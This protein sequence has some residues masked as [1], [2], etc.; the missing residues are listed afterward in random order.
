MTN[1][2]KYWRLAG[3]FVIII[4]MMMVLGIFSFQKTLS[5]SNLTTRLHEHPFAVSNA[6]RDVNL[7]IISMHRYLKDVALS[8]NSDDLEAAIVKIR[9]EEIDVYED[10][11]FIISRF[12]GNKSRI[13]EARKAFSHWGNIRAEVISLA[14]AGKYDEAARITKGKGAKH[15]ILMMG[16]MD[17]LINFAN[18]KAAEFL[19]NSKDQ[20]AEFQQMIALLLIGAFVMSGLI[21]IFII[22]SVRNADAKRNWA[23][24][25]LQAEHDNLE[26]KVEHRTKELTL[27]NEQVV[28]QR[29]IL[30]DI[31]RLTKAGGWE[32]D[33]ATMQ[34][35]WSDET[36]RIH[37][38]S[39]DFVPDIKN[40]IEFY[41]PES[42]PIIKAAVQKGIE[43]GTPLDMELSL[44]TAQG[45]L[46]NVRVLGE[47]I[48]EDQNPKTL[49]GTFQDITPQKQTEKE[50]KQAR[51]E[52]EKANKAKSE[53]LASMSHDLRTPL[54][55][56]MGFSDMMRAEIFGPLGNPHYEEYCEDINNSGSLLIS[57]INDVLDLSKIE[58]GKYELAEDALDIST[59]VHTS[60]KQLEKMS[61]TANQTISINIPTDLPPLKGDERALIQ[62]FNNLLSNAIKFTPDGG[63]INISAGVDETQKM[64]VIHF[65]DSGI[66][67]SK[68]G[69]IKA[70][71]P[72]EQA[73][74]SH[75]R[76][77]KGTGLGLHLCV[78]FMKLFGGTLNIESDV[79][80]GTKVTLQFPPERTLPVSAQAQNL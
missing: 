14:R 40:A 52:A 54:N 44:I 45:N 10:L 33:I 16:Q 57:L 35:K 2:V 63:N 80:E 19:K 51:D 17:G 47:V 73:E 1:R 67:M 66:G 79:G 36:Y 20:N 28:R 76:R 31:G 71:Q 62:T 61:K 18:N 53:F 23:E 37:E 56:I 43:D 72:F 3:G 15:V 42:R 60:F 49:L 41:A 21:A 9:E 24:M 30:E 7:D 69:I 50:L 11:D 32:V 22:S 75:S 39:D 26:I 5:L 48:Y 74:N 4:A 78:N 59:L 29:K 38:V 64:I 13:I 65:L 6:V 68:D 55:A 25:E 8:R 34:I 58:A 70:L 77:D 46:K 27:K 12:L